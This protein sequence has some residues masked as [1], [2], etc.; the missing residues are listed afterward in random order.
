MLAKQTWYRLLAIIVIISSA[1]AIYAASM[2]QDVSISQKRAQEIIQSELPHRVS[3]HALENLL[4]ISLNECQIEFH[5]NK[6]VI[7]FKV[8]MRII[9]KQISFSARSQGALRYAGNKFFFNNQQLE[10][11]QILLENFQK[12]DE[13]KAA[14]ISSAVNAAATAYLRMMPVYRLKDDFKGMIIRSA[15]KSVEVKEGEVIAHLSLW[16]LTKTV[17]LFVL[18]CILSTGLAIGIM[19]DVPGSGWLIASVLLPTD[20]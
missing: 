15:L 5:D 10:I 1:A 18:A 8:G 6:I 12:M 7:D 4:T 11:S 14:L 20:N 2:L 13:N 3:R 17:L 9:G 19:F 16:A